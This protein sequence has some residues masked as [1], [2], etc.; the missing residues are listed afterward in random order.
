MGRY[1]LLSNAQHGFV[2]S[3]STGTNLIDC[4]DQWTKLLDR[5]KFVDVIYL[6]VSKAF[7]TVCHEKLLHKM[8]YYKISKEI[9]AW[10]SDFLAHRNQRVMLENTL[11]DSVAFPSGVPQGSVLGPVL[12]ILFVNDLPLSITHGNISIYADDT[13]LYLGLHKDTYN[14]DA[15]LLNA[16]L[17]SVKQWFDTWQ[18]KI[19]VDKCHVLPLSVR[20]ARNVYEYKIDDTSL[21]PS[22]SVRDLGVLMDSNLT[23]HQHVSQ[24]VAKANSKSGLIFRCF[25]SRNQ[26]FLINLYKTFVRPLCEYASHVWNPHFIKDIKAI[27]CVQKRYTKRLAGLSDIS[28]PCRLDIVTLDSLELRRLKSDLIE[29]YKILNRLTVLDPD[30][31]IKFRG[32]LRTRHA[33]TMQSR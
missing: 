23:F 33:H 21:V 10:V 1:E 19:S 20:E 12:F 31:Y 5:G 25:K 28:Y 17:Q 6:D 22:N 18:L 7:D 26:A 11:S 16:D 29:F 3:R 8:N 32:P 15:V 14:A 24:V 27:E 30:S 13:K 2:K 9:V 4:V